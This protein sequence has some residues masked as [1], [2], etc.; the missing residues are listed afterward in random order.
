MPT[1]TPIPLVVPPKIAAQMLG[2]GKTHLFK[3]LR[4]G[5]LDSYLDGRRSRRIVVK[6]IESYVKRRLEADS[7]PARRGPGLPRKITNS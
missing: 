7:K 4:T 5:E 3:L 1:P 2:F 6:S